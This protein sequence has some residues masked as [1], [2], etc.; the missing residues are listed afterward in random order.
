[1]STLFN[2][3]PPEQSVWMSHG[4][5]VSQA[6]EGLRVTAT[7]PGAVVAAIEDD[8]RK[9]YGAVAPGGHALDIR[10]A[11]PGELPGARRRTGC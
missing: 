6:P 10:T 8:E 7:T 1:M 4:D 5:S 2:G 9:L 3:Q 11:R